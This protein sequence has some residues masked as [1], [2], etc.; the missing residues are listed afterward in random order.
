VDGGDGLVRGEGAVTRCVDGRLREHTAAAGRCRGPSVGALGGLGDERVAGG[1]EGELGVGEPAG[2]DAGGAHPADR[3]AV[4][5]DPRCAVEGGQVGA[6]R[7]SG[8]LVQLGHLLVQRRPAQH[9]GV[10][11]AGVPGGVATGPLLGLLPPGERGELEQGG[12]GGVLVGLLGVPVGRRGLGLG[13]VVVAGDVLEGGGQCR[14]GA[15]RRGPLGG[16]DFGAEG[17]CGCLGLSRVGEAG[18]GDVLAG[19]EQ[20]LE[21][22]DR[23]EGVVPVGDAALQHAAQRQ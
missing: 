8:A 19:R 23:V 18:E 9:G 6:Q 12:D 15:A 4:G 10:V 3:R 2:Q 20:G 13:G 14:T 21:R 16:G 17:A 5:G 1:V 22:E 7:Q 11:D